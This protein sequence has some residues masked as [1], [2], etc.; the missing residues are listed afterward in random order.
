MAFVEHFQ[1]EPD[2]EASFAAHAIQVAAVV[3]QSAVAGQHVV[4]QIQKVDGFINA[5]QSTG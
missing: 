3:N 5:R 2:T 4:T 1:P